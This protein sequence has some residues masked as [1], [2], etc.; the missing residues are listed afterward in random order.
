M[1]PRHIASTDGVTLAVHD[2][3]GHDQ[4]GH[5]REILYSH[6]TGFHGRVW[7][8]FADHLS[9]RYHGWAIDYRGHGDSTSAP[10]GVIAWSDYGDDCT[11]VLDALALVP[12]LFG[13]G[14]SKGGVSLLM[15][16]R[17][18]PGTFA[19]LALYEPV[20]FPPDFERNG[21]GPSM[22]IE[23]A[24]RRRA[25]FGSYEAAI[26]NFSSKPPLNALAPAALDAYVRYGFAL[27]AEGTVRL[28]C[29]PEH[30]ARTYEGG[31]AHRAWD[32][33]DEIWCPVLIMSGDPRA[34]GPGPMAPQV[35]A[36]LPHGRH[37][38]FAHLSHFGPLQDP[39]GVAGAVARYFAEISGA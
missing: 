2:L 27:T 30:E 36:R 12:P 31:P 32:W 11:A 24:R 37:Q 8:P 20:V 35:A 14:H 4:S 21:D 23:G 34:I 39:E 26:E 15:S 7:T 25:E 9:D 22:L 28:K 33:L 29:E 10:D 5:G 3:G 18:R 19:A 13:V 16:E 17:A 1:T 38:G 6:A